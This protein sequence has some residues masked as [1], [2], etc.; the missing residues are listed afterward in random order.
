[1]DEKSTEMRALTFRLPADQAERLEH[2]A[3]YLGTTLTGLLRTALN[4]WEENHAAQVGAAGDQAIAVLENG[5]RLFGFS[6]Q[7]LE[8][9]VSGDAA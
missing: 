1:M 8:T 4:E 7:I 5:Y 9:D 6:R 2:V 3:E